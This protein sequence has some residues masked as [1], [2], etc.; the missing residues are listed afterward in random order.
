MKFE[1][2]REWLAKKLARCDDANVAAG[3]TP[4]E[5]FKRDVERRTVTPSVLDNVPTQLGKAV[6]YIREQK[7]WTR[8]ELA[9]LADVDEADV[10]QLETQRDF[11]PSPRTVI[12]L[13]Q[14]CRFSKEKFIQLAGHRSARAANDNSVR[15]A[16]NS[17]DL[18]SITDDDYETIRALV[19]VLSQD[20]SGIK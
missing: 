17:G 11:D 4:L 8:A 20:S 13:A 9:Q 1:M 12:Q 7:G 6:R 10:R 2:T 18:A 19:E 14:A 16:A 5:D 3:G 15:F